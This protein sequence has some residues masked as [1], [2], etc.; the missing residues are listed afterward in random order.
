MST[1]ER[2]LAHIGVDEN[3][4]WLWQANKD[5]KGYGQM[6]IGSR[7]DGS[8]RNAMAY[9]VAY[10]VFKGEIPAG[11]HLDHLCRVHACVNPNHLE[12]VTPKENNH[13]GN[14]A[15]KQAK[16]KTHCLRGHELSGKDV[17]TYTSSQGTMRRKCAVCHRTAQNAKKALIR[18]ETVN[19]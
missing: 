1:K 5:T 6:T 15:W 11:L 2:I 12:P 8:R 18:Q 3:G 17:Y 7:T 4:C 13:R 16:A 19:V 9:R 14:P 10:E